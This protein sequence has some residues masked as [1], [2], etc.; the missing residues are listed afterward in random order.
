MKVGRGEGV[1]SI[2]LSAQISLLCNIKGHEVT[3]VRLDGIGP[4]RLLPMTRLG[5]V[6]NVEKN[7]LCY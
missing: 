1:S 6:W 4:V 7:R 5:I 2:D 3:Y